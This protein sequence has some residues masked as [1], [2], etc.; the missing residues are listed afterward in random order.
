MDNSQIVQYSKTYLKIYDTISKTIA[1]D[2]MLEKRLL[3]IA[4]AMLD[5]IY[6]F[7]NRRYCMQFINNLFHSYQLVDQV[8]KFT[9]NVLKTMIRFKTKIDDNLINSYITSQDPAILKR[10]GSLSRMM[11]NPRNMKKLYLI[12]KQLSQTKEM[13]ALNQLRKYVKT[14]VEI[15][16]NKIDVATIDR[17]RL[18]ALILLFFIHRFFPGKFQTGLTFVRRFLNMIIK[19]NQVQDIDELDKLDTESDD[20]SESESDLNTEVESNTISNSNIEGG[21]GLFNGYR[22]AITRKNNSIMITVPIEFINRKRDSFNQASRDVNSY[23]NMETELS[24]DQFMK[25][26]SSL[27]IK[28]T[29]FY[30]YNIELKP[31]NGNYVI[32]R[33]EYDV[34]SRSLSKNGP[35]IIQVTED[36]IKNTFNIELK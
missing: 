30:F 27:G 1:I 29:K 3:I 15:D 4:P 14:D 33:A 18:M 19:S 6:S 22:V 21:P 7:N 10:I 20:E 28:P 16:D 8:E 32:T 11:I 36:E 25:Y 34:S 12:L 24:S 13:S 9:E 17:G 23:E 35:Q 26:L 31:V 5:V 2:Q